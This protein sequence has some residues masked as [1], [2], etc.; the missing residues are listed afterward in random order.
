MGYS[1]RFSPLRFFLSPPFLPRSVRK[2]DSISGDGST[3]VRLWI[4]LDCSVLGF[5]NTAYC[6]VACLSRSITPHRLLVWLR[7]QTALWKCV[8]IAYFLAGTSCQRVDE[9][10]RSSSQL[11]FLLHR[12]WLARIVVIG[13]LLLPR[14]HPLDQCNPP[15]CQHCYKH[16]RQGRYKSSSLGS[17]WPGR[18]HSLHHGTPP[19]RALH[20]RQRPF[21]A[22]HT[23]IRALRP[24]SSRRG[25]DFRCKR[26]ELGCK[27]AGE[28]AL[29]VNLS[30]HADDQT[31]TLYTELAQLS[32]DLLAHD[33]KPLYGCLEDTLHAESLVPFLATRMQYINVHPPQLISEPVPHNVCAHT[34]DE[35]FVVTC[36]CLHGCDST[37]GLPYGELGFSPGEA[38]QQSTPVRTKRHTGNAPPN[39]PIVAGVSPRRYV[40]TLQ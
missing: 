21:S 37:P 13:H 10:I 29:P 31:A 12:G 22:V 33:M 35:T 16:L 3:L 18:M 4:A 20:H 24:A 38:K 7:L 8:E 23:S 28:G 30:V 26:R 17:S 5:C 15:R 9:L 40:G 2:A 19:G 25:C 39:Q 36:H 14:R 27:S 11:A 32:G 1:R 34:T 6:V